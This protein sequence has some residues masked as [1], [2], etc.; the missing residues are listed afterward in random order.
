MIANR[1]AKK[2]KNCFWMSKNWCHLCA[3]HLPNLAVCQPILMVY[4]NVSVLTAEAQHGL[5]TG[6]A[7]AL[8]WHNA[9]LT[10]NA[11]TLFCTVLWCVKLYGILLYGEWITESV[12]RPTIV[13]EPLG[14]GLVLSVAAYLPMFITINGFQ[15]NFSYVSLIWW[16]AVNS[17]TLAPAIRWPSLRHPCTATL[18]N[19]SLV[20]GHQWIGS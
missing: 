18:L 3:I 20:N 14:S 2:W 9:S 5:S 16:L 6:T 13:A 8:H 19:L 7:L 11:L 17:A 4:R 10:P 12:N 15:F 1:S